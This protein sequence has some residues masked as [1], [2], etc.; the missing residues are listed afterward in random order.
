MGSVLSSRS[1][2]LTVLWLV[3]PWGQSHAGGEGTPRFLCRSLSSFPLPATSQHLADSAHRGQSHPRLTGTAG[4]GPCAASKVNSTPRHR[5]RGTVKHKHTTACKVRM[6]Q[7]LVCLKRK[8]EPPNA[9]SPDQL[10]LVSFFESL[11]SVSLCYTKSPL[12]K[13]ARGRLSGEYLSIGKTAFFFFVHTVC[14]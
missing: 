12:L 6:W 9:N 14:P 10:G 3:Y 11:P 5:I 8:A 7:E 4:A 13:E 1:D 2:V